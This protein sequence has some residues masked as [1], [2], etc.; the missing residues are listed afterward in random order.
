MERVDLQ[1]LL[2]RTDRTPAEEEALMTLLR[3]AAHRALARERPGS[4]ETGDLAGDVY[5]RLA[6]GCDLTIED[7]LHLRRLV[8]RVTRHV[9][10]DRARRRGAERRGADPVRVTYSE[11]QL[12]D[13]GLDLDVLALHALLDRLG[14]LDPRAAEI[15]QMRAFGGA[16]AREVAE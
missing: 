8:A 6:T 3:T 14:E 9:L 2:G 5:L 11:R 15:V 13:D 1:A 12:A 16:S 4:L 10:V 7:A